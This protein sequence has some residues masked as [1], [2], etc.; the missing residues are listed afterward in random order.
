[1][2][3]R[4]DRTRAERR[5]RARYR[6][7]PS[8][9]NDLDDMS[10]FCKVAPAAA[11]SVLLLLLVVGP[12]Q[13]SRWTVWAGARVP[14]LRE[15]GSLRLFRRGARLGRRSLHPRRLLLGGGRSQTSA[16]R[17]LGFVAK[18]KR[19]QAAPATRAIVGHW[20]MLAGRNGHSLDDELTIVAAISGRKRMAVCPESVRVVLGWRYHEARAGLRVAFRTGD[21][22]PPA[23]LTLLAK[24]A[25]I[26]TGW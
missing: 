8:A 21:L 12:E 16:P 4:L 14:L 7:N 13:K 18:R 24:P 11:R 10:C 20:P 26:R 15:S 25:A 9:N 23:D 22:C 1:M 2:H 3:Q 6:V 5:R 17:T 19:A